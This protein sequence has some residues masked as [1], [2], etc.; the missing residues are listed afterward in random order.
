MKITDSYTKQLLYDAVCGSLQLQHMNNTIGADS[1]SNIFFIY[2]SS[3]PI[4]HARLVS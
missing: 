2:S 1:N 4:S 3:C